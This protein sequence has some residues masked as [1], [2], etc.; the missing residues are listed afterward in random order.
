MNTH[1]ES[2][3]DKKEKENTYLLNVKCNNCGHKWELEI[4]KGLFFVS[5]AG[6][7]KYSRTPLTA[8]SRNS[9]GY[10]WKDLV[11]CPNCGCNDIGKKL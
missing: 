11:E 3:K 6:N 8:L 1:K 2:R 9:D 7:S 5:G 10:M 4:E